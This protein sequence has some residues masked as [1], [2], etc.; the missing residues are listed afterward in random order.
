L[1]ITLKEISIGE[2]RLEEMAKKA[3]KAAFGTEQ[4]IGGLKK[5][6]WQDVLEIY[7]LVK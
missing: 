2:D 4:A 7:K 5:L 6:H 1:P 3:T